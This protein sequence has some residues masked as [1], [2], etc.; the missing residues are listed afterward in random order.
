MHRKGAGGGWQEAK[1]FAPNAARSL[2]DRPQ[3]QSAVCGSQTP[4]CKRSPDK[5][6]RA[7]H[8]FNNFRRAVIIGL[9][10]C[11]HWGDWHSKGL[12]GE[13][14]SKNLRGLGEGAGTSPAGEMCSAGPSA[15]QGRGHRDTAWLQRCRI[16]APQVGG[17]GQ[18]AQPGAKPHRDALTA[19]GR[20]GWKQVGPSGHQVPGV[21]SNGSQ[22]TDANDHT[23]TGKHLGGFETLVP[24]SL[25]I[26]H[27]CVV[28]ARRLCTAWCAGSCAEL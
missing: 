14:E 20:A 7:S 28:T 21:A 13:A 5:A 11:C 24:A 18:P 22:E 23:G 17:R 9:P 15:W 10:L 1:A 8:A 25:V 6:H 26:N 3:R 2:T 19:G 16:P 27:R 4:K 12:L